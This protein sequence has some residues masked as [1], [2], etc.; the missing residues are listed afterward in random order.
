LS[1]CRARW[2]KGR[3]GKQTMR[4]MI[5]GPIYAPLGGNPSELSGESL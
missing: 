5:D 3:A 4:L 2:T 1:A